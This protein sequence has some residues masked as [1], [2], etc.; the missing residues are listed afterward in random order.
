MMK[1][2]KH[3]LI[4]GFFL[5]ILFVPAC[6]DAIIPSETD[7]V[8]YGWVLYEDGDYVGANQWFKDGFEKDSSYMDAYNGLGWSFGKLGL[9]DSAIIYFVLGKEL[10]WDDTKTP[11]L[12][13]QFYAGLT[14]A[15]NAVANDTLARSYGEQF[16]G[17]QNL[18][19]Q[20]PWAFAHNALTNHLDVR[21]TLASTYFSL[22]FLDLCITEVR[23]IHSDLGMTKT[24]EPDLNTVQ[25]R[26][27]LVKELEILQVLLLTQ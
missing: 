3:I 5:S 17:A 15:N 27:E 19:D 12:D 18:V 11:D 6:R 4:V 21:L 16:F 26:D 7:L 25:G 24:F 10:T 23:Q 2:K 8:D 20:D 14:F 1:S 22:S 9:A 13:M